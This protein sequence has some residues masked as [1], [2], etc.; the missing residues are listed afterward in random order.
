MVVATSS[1]AFDQ[2][3]GSGEAACVKEEPEADGA[4]AA[5]QN[6]T[7]PSVKEEP[8]L[9]DSIAMAANFRLEDFE[10][11]LPPSEASAKALV[12]F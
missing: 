5:G 12:L 7:L 4:N 3:M 11:P 6:G 8:N 1:S 9:A 2:G 10:I